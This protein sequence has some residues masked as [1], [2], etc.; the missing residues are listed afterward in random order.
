MRDDFFNEFEKR[1]RT[2]EDFER[3]PRREK[4]DDVGEKEEK[5]Q[6]TT[7]LVQNGKRR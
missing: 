5:G 3:F 1:S 2:I 7:L 6:D 4:K